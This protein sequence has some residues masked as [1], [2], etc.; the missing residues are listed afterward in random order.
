MK[1]PS[2]FDGMRLTLEQA[3]E[4][5]IDSL[6]QYGARYRHWAL[7]YSGGKDSSAAVTFV[8]W[9]IRS[10]L[11]SAPE[12]LTVLYADTRLELPPLQSTALDLLATLRA[13]GFSARVVLPPIDDRFLVYMLGYGVP[14][15]SNTFRWCT[16]RIKVEPMLA[17]LE[18]LREQHGK[19][20]ML[21]GVRVGESAARDRRI[22]VSCSVNGGECGQGWFQVS[23][24]ES[25]AD[26][27]APL[28]QWR[29]CHV[30][31]WL[32]YDPLGHGYEVP[33]VADVYGED[34]VRTGC[35]GCPL[36]SRDVALERVIR[37]SEW[38]HLTPLLELK[39]LW[40]ELKQ[41]RWR[42][43]KTE[44]ER[45]K[46]GQ[47]GRNVQRMGPLTMD[48][49]EYGLTRVLDIQARAGFELV[50]RDEET[51]IREMWALDMWPRKWSARD[52]DA[53]AP[54]R[55]AL[56]VTLDGQ[57]VSQAVIPL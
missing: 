37:K 5:S 21:T 1:Q 50:N 42:K 10:G 31:D 44:P 43:R 4:Q 41:A 17:A 30:Y 13:E 32:Y 15:S 54:L 45:R 6:N 27:L 39:P 2:L 19:L 49:R 28:L 12:S 51:R 33:G 36:A 47:Y 46:D 25:T 11:V 16:Q 23:T 7:A 24:P 34:E 9:A 3:V 55:E 29:V 40:R 56:R 52:V 20:L 14:P 48:G 38:A 22:A 35:V 57:L 8:V 18:E 26:T 53:D